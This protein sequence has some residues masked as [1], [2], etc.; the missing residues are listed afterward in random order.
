VDYGL[1]LPFYSNV[2]WEE[3]K[4]TGPEDSYQTLI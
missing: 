2:V 4:M 1:Y 3:A